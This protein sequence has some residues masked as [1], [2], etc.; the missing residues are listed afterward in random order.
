MNRLQAF[1]IARIAYKEMNAV[2]EKWNHG[3]IDYLPVKF[4]WDGCIT[5]GEEFFNEYELAEYQD[6]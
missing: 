4:H 2:V 6:D 1:K 5:V 3:V